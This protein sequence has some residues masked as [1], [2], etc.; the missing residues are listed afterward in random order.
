MSFVDAAKYL[1]KNENL[2]K[3]I[4]KLQMNCVAS[5]RIYFYIFCFP[6]Y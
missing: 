3:F 6:R 5:H 1:Y 4:F 2:D